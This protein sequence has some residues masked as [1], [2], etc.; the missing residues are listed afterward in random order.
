MWERFFFEL[1]V[2]VDSHSRRNR[3]NAKNDHNSTIHQSNLQTLPK[4]TPTR[5]ETN[6][7][8]IGSGVELYIDRTVLISRWKYRMVLSCLVA[9]LDFFEGA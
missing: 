4:V 1:F 2:F 3:I 5:F 8:G 9:G 7:G 6:F